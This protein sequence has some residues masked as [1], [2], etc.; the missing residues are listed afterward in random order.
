VRKITLYHHLDGS[1]SLREGAG[2]EAVEAEIED[3]YLPVQGTGGQPRVL[4]SRS[5]E[6]GM[7][8]EQAIRRGLLRMLPSEGTQ[9]DRPTMV[10][11]IEHV[12]RVKK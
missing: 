11:P 6:L 12:Q 1:W 7:T 5:D 4:S 8:M 9:S 2:S 3:G 10:D